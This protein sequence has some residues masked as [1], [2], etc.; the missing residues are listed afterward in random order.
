VT[1]FARHARLGSLHA[2]SFD[3]VHR[4]DYSKL[5]KR[6]TIHQAKTQFSKLLRQASRGET[7]VV[8]NRRKPVAQIVPVLEGDRRL[9][10]F[11][12]Q[13]WTAP[14]FDEPLEDFQEYME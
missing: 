11:R 10:R 6:Y 7:V 1:W 4:L 8:V 13:V 3:L 2:A 5:V 12:G 14:D 9:G